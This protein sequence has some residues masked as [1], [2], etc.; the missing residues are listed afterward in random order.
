MLKRPRLFDILLR[1][2]QRLE[3]LGMK[4]MYHVN[5]IAEHDNQFRAGGKG[6]QGFDGDLR[7]HVANAALAQR[8]MLRGG[9]LKKAKVLF[10]G[11]HKANAWKVAAKI[12]GLFL[13]TEEDAGVLIEILSQSC[14]TA[15]RGADDKEV[16][17]IHDR[18][19]G[20]SIRGLWEAQRALD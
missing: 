17:T 10:L 12:I 14:S 16:W 2:V 15:L 1:F 20:F 6:V 5:G 9:A 4:R 8:P 18:N 19:R 7:V 11:A 3:R 13:W